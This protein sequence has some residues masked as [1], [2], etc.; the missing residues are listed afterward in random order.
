MGYGSVGVHQL[1]QAL[2]GDKVVTVV[3]VFED[4]LLNGVPE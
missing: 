1:R 4:L 2:D 3:S